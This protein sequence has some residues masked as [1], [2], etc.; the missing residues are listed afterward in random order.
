MSG[1]DAPDPKEL[2]EAA[3]SHYLKLNR[4]AHWA[5]DPQGREH[6]KLQLHWHGYLIWARLYPED[7]HITLK[8]EWGQTQQMP[9]TEGTLR[10]I[11]SWT[12]EET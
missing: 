6:L 10:V 1:R 5:K 3:R 4:D 8:D 11:K 12:E 2:L 7:G 9:S